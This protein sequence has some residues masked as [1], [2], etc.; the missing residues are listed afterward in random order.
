LKPNYLRLSGFICGYDLE[1]TQ[2]KTATHAGGDLPSEPV[3]LL[4]MPVNRT[5]Q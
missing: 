5:G 4:I 2:I 1:T 3:Y